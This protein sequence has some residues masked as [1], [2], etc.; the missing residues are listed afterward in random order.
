MKYGEMTCVC[1]HQFMKGYNEIGGE[2]QAFNLPTVQTKYLSVE[3]HTVPDHM[4][5]NSLSFS[6]QSVSNALLLTVTKTKWWCFMYYLLFFHTVIKLYERMAHVT[7]CSVI[8]VKLT[9]PSNNQVTCGGGSPVM[10]TSSVSVKPT[11]TTRFCKF[12]RSIVGFTGGGKKNTSTYFSLLWSTVYNIQYT[13]TPAVKQ[14]NS[15][16]SS[17]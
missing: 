11:F 13:R 4:R 16:Y 7:T 8:K 10:L 12:V 3:P 6:K 5:C 17:P 1:K 14:F 9:F 15:P 2:V